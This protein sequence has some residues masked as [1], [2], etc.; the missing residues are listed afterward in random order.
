MQTSLSSNG[1]MLKKNLNTLKRYIDVCSDIKFSI[2]GCTKDVYEK[3]RFGGKW[4]DLLAN[5]E[6]AL[7]ELEPLGYR[8]SV[9]NIL[10]KEN[11]HQAGEYINFF[12]KYF[13]YPHER[14]EFDLLNSLSP[15]NDFFFKNNLFDKDT[16]LNKFCTLV[17]NPIPFILVD[18]SLSVCCRDYDGSLI[19]GDTKKDSIDE[20]FESDKF[21]ELQIAHSDKGSNSFS[22]WSLCNSCY[23]VDDRIS[24]IFTN[25]VKM[26]ILKF[27]GND[28][29]FF[30]RKIEKIVKFLGNINTHTSY[31]DFE[32]ELLN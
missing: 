27:K 28:G 23:I 5:F 11:Y 3:I 17:S 10:M 21:K 20:I 25:L 29:F 9:L 6:I 31:I 19:I 1:L 14:V 24:F 7:N 16:Y 15:S 32:R 2:D 12:S 30:Q 26:I 18:G 4:E 13:K 22:K 8:I